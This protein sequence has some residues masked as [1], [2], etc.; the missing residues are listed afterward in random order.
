[1]S[2]GGQGTNQ[3]EFDDSELEVNLGASFFVERVGQGNVEDLR[4]ATLMSGRTT[5]RVLKT[6]TEEAPE[7]GRKQTIL[8]RE[9]KAKKH[10]SQYVDLS[11]MDESQIEEKQVSQ[12]PARFSM[13]SQQRKETVKPRKETIKPRKESVIQ[14]GDSE[15]LT[16]EEDKA[17]EYEFGEK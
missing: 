12:N 6:I 10:N 15:S 3:F 8:R 5:I 11:E 17:D 13:R 14:I 7:P 2:K 9:T 4:R 16:D 1:M